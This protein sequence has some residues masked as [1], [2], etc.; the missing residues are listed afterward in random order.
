MQVGRT[1][2]ITGGASGIAPAYVRSSAARGDGQNRNLEHWLAGVVRMQA[3]LET[4]EQS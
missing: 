1:T 3:T 4:E 2:I